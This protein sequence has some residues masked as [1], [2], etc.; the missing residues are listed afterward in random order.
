MKAKSKGL[1]TILTNLA[2]MALFAVPL[3]FAA[4]C[5]DV[6]NS[7]KANT[8]DGSTSIVRISIQNA[9][10]RTVLP[11]SPV[12]S[13]Y[14]LAAAPVNAEGVAVTGNPVTGTFDAEDDLVLELTGGYWKISAEGLLADSKVVLA[15][16]ST[17]VQVAAGVS[18]PVS[19]TLYPVTNQ[20]NG[21]FHYGVTLPADL[22]KAELRIYDDTDDLAEASPGDLLPGGKNGD[23]SLA[24][25]VYTLVLDMANAYQEI[26]R[27]EKVH[28]YSNLTSSKTYTITAGDF[29]NVAHLTGTA[30]LVIT[31]A[32]GLE[33]GDNIHAYS[34]A[35]RTEEYWLGTSALAVDTN[36]WDMYIPAA[37]ATV[38]FKAEGTPF[39]YDS[40]GS[41]STAT[42]AVGEVSFQGPHLLVYN[43]GEVG[44]TG[45]TASGNAPALE[46]TQLGNSRLV[47]R[48]NIEGAGF[49][50]TETEVTRKNTVVYLNTA[51]TGDFSVSARIKMTARNN[52]VAGGANGV[53]IGALSNPDGTVRFAGLRFGADGLIRHYRSTNET[54]TNSAT[55]DTE[56]K[57][58]QDEYIFKLERAGNAYTAG[59]YASD[60]T[61]SAIKTWTIS[62]M[63]ASVNGTAAVYPGFIVSNVDV[64]F[65]NIEITYRT[66][67][68][69]YKTPEADRSR[70]L[71]DEIDID[72]DT[73]TAPGSGGGY[74]Y[75]THL[76]AFPSGGITLAATVSPDNADNQTYIWSIGTEVEGGYSVTGSVGFDNVEGNKK[77]VTVTGWAGVITVTATANDAGGVTG[78]YKI[79]VN[80][81][82]PKVGSITVSRD[83]GETSAIIAGDG[84]QD[85]G[86]TLALSASVLPAGADYGSLTWKVQDT[87]TY[88]EEAAST[89]AT[90]TEPSGTTATLKAQDAVLDVEQ[91]VYVFAVSPGDKNEPGVVFTPLTVTIA[92][93]PKPASVAVSGPNAVIAG[94]DTGNSG[95]KIQLAAALLP[96]GATQTVTWVVSDSSTYNSGGTSTY[97][98]ISATG[99]LTATDT[100]LTE[101]KTVYVFAAS[102]AD[103]EG[104]GKAV[105]DAHTVTVQTFRYH[106][107]FQTDGTVGAALFDTTGTKT[108]TIGRGS[109]TPTQAIPT[110]DCGFSIGALVP[111]GNNTWGT[112]IGMQGPLTVI[113]NY[114]S[115]TSGSGRYPTVK[116]GNDEAV[117]GTGST[118][119]TDPQTVTVPYAGTDVVS[120]V[121]SSTSTPGRI[122]DVFVVPAKPTPVA[123]V[124]IMDN[125][126]SAT[127]FT[128][129][130]AN[131]GP[132]PTKTLTVAILPANAT[133]QTVIWASGSE[134]V[135]TVAGGVVTAVG[136]GTST[137]SATA[138]DGSGKTDSVTVTVSPK[139]V[140]SVTVSGGPAEVQTNTAT[141]TY[142]ATL[143]PTDAYYQDIKW[144][145][146]D[147]NSATVDST[148]SNATINS[149]TGVLTTGSA[150]A[151]VYVFAIVTQASGNS[152]DIV[153]TG[154]EVTIAS[155][156]ANVP[157]TGIAIS[158]A[159]DADEITAGATEGPVA[160]E[161]LQFSAEVLPSNATNGAYTWAVK[162]SATYA[163]AEN[164]TAASIN[165]SGLLTAATDLAAN[166]DVWVYAVA[167]DASGVVSGGYQVTVK[168]YVAPVLY[169]DVSILM[170]NE[171][172]V[173]AGTIGN[174][175]RT[176]GL[177]TFINGAGSNFGVFSQNRTY[178][179]ITFTYRLRFGGGSTAITNRTV[180]LTPLAACEITIWAY[181][182]SGRVLRTYYD[183]AVK[184]TYDVSS[185][186]KFSFSAT[187]K[188][189]YFY[190]SDDVEISRIDIDY[191]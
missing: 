95:K 132:A 51:V 88:N 15:G 105:S 49:G 121:L 38:Y 168:K 158:A 164:A 152:D 28:I 163:G 126:A 23:V 70:I 131:S 108:L 156:V 39:D 184:E 112:I 125:E 36:A 12:V 82:A 64:Q 66:D 167:S 100:W 25:G 56:T 63:T 47:I 76:A 149:S 94:N 80:S 89:Y 26:T 45:T 140:T 57:T 87:E 133:D 1:H 5:T 96:V 40:L 137:I 154:Q 7:S 142:T 160:A 20:G 21:T 115:N 120:I 99:E 145:V 179:G 59:Y 37:A 135:A 52:E 109:T 83:D 141:A 181:G 91:M 32:V 48:N 170:S 14:K 86:E 166:T 4:G 176:V 106:W 157:V 42:P 116:I 123:S 161:T 155:E 117:A 174:E 19:I 153:S 55:G 169:E 34:N 111:G 162:D 119:T 183:G 188:D 101:N 8:G 58:W 136:L 146:S 128:L 53:I 151:T 60:G 85:S 172:Y 46:D 147:S 165:G 13:Q 22:T 17:V 18:N 143:D 27:T 41:T 124:D 6:L 175:T 118:A 43:Q 159:G 67:K 81:V 11:E 75:I 130:L 93:R 103:K 33:L 180:K 173:S 68:T 90:V 73:G 190:C 69:L 191:P 2:K 92:P 79:L 122:F 178:E 10:P 65:S 107:N 139:A 185:G 129:T 177:L 24:P 9:A 77:K 134:S 189:Y 187:A 138:N 104:G 44:E 102:T 186:K 3:L 54:T 182:S 110:P 35:A 171:P 78:E 62:G 31:G 29:V 50:N 84:A 113:V 98:A 61:D 97:A 127:N 74:D 72:L 71:V 30:K 114:A 144:V 150:T 148:S 16:E